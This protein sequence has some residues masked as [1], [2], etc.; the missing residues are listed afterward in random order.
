MVRGKQ[1][2][3]AANKRRAQAESTI[4]QLKSEL[5]SEMQLIADV[6]EAKEEAQQTKARFREE[7]SDLLAS[8]RPHVERLEDEV[9]YLTEV[10]VAMR[11]S[12]KGVRDAWGKY[13]QHGVNASPG[14]THVE[15]VEA[16]FASFQGNSMVFM[17]SNS[18]TSLSREQY[19]RLQR[20]KGERAEVSEDPESKAALLSLTSRWFRPDLRNRLHQV[21]LV[22]ESG[23]VIAEPED[24]NGEQV[25]ALEE[26]AEVIEKIRDS[27]AS[28][29]DP[30]RLPVW[31]PG[32][33]VKRGH[34]TAATLAHLG[35]SDNAYPAVS[36]RG[37]LPSLPLP[38]ISS[39]T[40]SAIATMEPGEVIDAWKPALR[41]RHAV[42][43]TLAGAV[44]PFMPMPPH[45]RPS[46][47][48]VFQHL[49]SLSA[50]GDWARLG[51]GHRAETLA[52]TGLTS[53]AA[54]WLPTGQT[55]SFADS[56]PVDEEAK[57]EMSLPFPQVFLAFAEPLELEPTTP[58]DPHTASA[59]RAMSLCAMS[60]RKGWY[61]ALATLQEVQR[62]V[63]GGELTLTEDIIAQ[64]G[65]KVEGILLLSDDLSR[66]VDEFAW[67]LSLASDYGE[68]IGRVVVPARRSATA[69][70][71]LIDN[72]TA[73]VSWANWHEP[74]SYTEIPLGMKPDDV[75]DFINSEDFKNDAQRA[76]AGVR[77]ID[78]ERTSRGGGKSKT[79]GRHVDPHIRRGHWRK[80]RHGQGLSKIK[81]VRISPTLVNAHRGD[82]EGARVYRIR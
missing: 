70:K 36:G 4:A 44:S 41:T 22:T 21:G 71:D 27:T 53:A 34:D 66:P 15:R 35:A 43:K 39:R 13:V 59:V 49:Y 17:D 10:L 60:A 20:A 42:T 82:A 8:S 14:D 51:R 9:D 26:M 7:T 57:A 54:Y 69:H 24:P 72:L 48:V 40:R 81:M 3:K 5:D 58:L 2:A 32:P 75:A 37:S 6:A 80:Q 64:K 67:C 77:V 61:S 55:A 50:L 25:D 68:S 16:F 12:D 38:S 62:N 30:D 73:V 28:V 74:D 78:T 65:A 63:E 46:Q 31:G 29:I 19:L 47:G 18:K 45:S 1:K 23:N 56:D 76:G 79:G 11:G 52:A 33:L